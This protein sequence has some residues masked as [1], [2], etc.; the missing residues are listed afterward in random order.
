MGDGYQSKK[1]SGLD[2]DGLFVVNSDSKKIEIAK[3]LHEKYRDLIFIDDK[4][5]V[6]EKMNANGIESFQALWFLDEK[7][8]KNSFDKHFNKAREILEI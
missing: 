1:I 8:R 5:T 3:A 4:K 2:I 7:Y 6:V